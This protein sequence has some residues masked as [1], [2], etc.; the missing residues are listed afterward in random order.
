[1]SAIASGLQSV[2]AQAEASSTLQCLPIILLSTALFSTPL[3]PRKLLTSIRI[4]LFSSDLEE[5]SAILWD[6]TNHV[7]FIASKT[8]FLSSSLKRLP[9]SLRLNSSP[10]C[11]PLVLTFASRVAHTVGFLFC[12]QWFLHPPTFYAKLKSAWH[13]NNGVMRMRPS[14][15]AIS[16]LDRIERKPIRLTPDL[17]SATV[18]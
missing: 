10:C 6:S 9:Y 14:S 8:S 18:C 11:F 15:T 3:L 16:S 2:D 1:M 13:L 12:A 5:I 7:C 17:Q 4:A